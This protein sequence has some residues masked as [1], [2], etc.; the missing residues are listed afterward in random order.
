[1]IMAISKATPDVV[2]H[3]ASFVL[4][5][6]TFT[7]QAF[8][9]CTSKSE[10]ADALVKSSSPWSILVTDRPIAVFSL[11][12][13]DSSATLEQ[14]CPES[15]DS[16]KAIVFSL[17]DHLKRM[18]VQTFTIDLPEDLSG[19][20]GDCGLDRRASL[21]RLV[22]KV[23]E[24]DFMPILPLSNPTQKDISVL[25]RLAYDS[26]DKTGFRLSDVASAERMLNDIWGGLR[27]AFLANSSFISNASGKIVSGCLLS[28]NGPNAARIVE[29]FTHPLYRARGL[30]TAEV[31]TSMNQLSK[32]GVSTVSVTVGEDNEV[33]KR[34][35]SKL[36]FRLGPKLV[37]MGM[38]VR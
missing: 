34:L 37:R 28:S 21:A 30:A 4:A 13:S 9:D 6:K 23:V 10:V 1:M 14:F 35:F 11:Y 12:I 24:T 33:A 3:V 26:Y 25:A 36:A 32:S 17:Q 29:L 38:Q 27:G 15:Q 2:N 18:K 31:A 16:L 5:N 22:G 7:S 8:M 20:L 19:L